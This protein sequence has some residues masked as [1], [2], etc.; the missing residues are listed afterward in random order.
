MKRE[1]ATILNRGLLLRKRQN[2]ENAPAIGQSRATA[3][4]ARPVER[5]EGS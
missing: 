5:G 3:F 2:D 1:V 4:D